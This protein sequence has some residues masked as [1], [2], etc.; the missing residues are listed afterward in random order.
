MKVF[1]VLALALLA[2]VQ[3]SHQE[4]IER[5]DVEGQFDV[6][7]TGDD[8]FDDQIIGGRNHTNGRY[9]G[10][11]L[12]LG[13]YIG[14]GVLV[15]RTHLLTSAQVVINKADNIEYDPLEVVVA[16]GF[17]STNNPGRGHRQIRAQ[18]LVAH[19]D[20]KGAVDN[21][22]HNIAVVTLR[23]PIRRNQLLAPITLP[24]TRPSPPVKRQ[25]SVASWG[26]ASVAGGLPTLLQIAKVRTTPSD[27]YLKANPNA[28]LSE[29]QIYLKSFEGTVVPTDTGAPL[30][31]Q[32][33]LAGI[34]SHVQ[35]GNTAIALDLKPYLDW[36]DEVTAV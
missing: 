3:I 29:N 21:H 35:A 9:T 25:V 24:R 31:Y 28:Q 5:A 12:R 36:F 22:A 1:V 30:F 10:R 6:A 8:D 19:F 33:R 20:Y 18:S 14:N 4:E 26:Q 2:A 34:V 32:R 7:A 23:L 15:S 11:I 17:T 16:V 13:K 27:E